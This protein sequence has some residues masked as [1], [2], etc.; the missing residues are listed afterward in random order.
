MPTFIIRNIVEIILIRISTLAVIKSDRSTFGF[1]R[2]GTIPLLLL[3]DFLLGYAIN[4]KQI[5]GIIII[6]MALLFAF[7]NHG[8]RKNGLKFVIF[9]TILPVIT[10][11]L[12]KYNITHFNSVETEQFLSHIFS[13]I[14]TFIAAVKFGRENPL[15]MLTK[16]IFFTQSFTA[17]IG[18]VLAS[19]AF[20]FAPASVIT[21]II[22]AASVFW[23]IISGNI[24]FQEKQLI[25]K[26]IIF[27]LISVGIILLA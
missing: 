22:R 5:S 16:R 26:I 12:Y 3:V 14:Y 9:S 27:S 25:F 20:I 17:G 7:I 15:S 10:I 13:L 11:S 2:T 18:G 8:L 23:A 21:A 19:F 6:V 24:Y 4:L 1:V